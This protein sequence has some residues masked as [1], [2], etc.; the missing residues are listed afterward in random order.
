ME[1]EKPVQLL[2]HIPSSL[3]IRVATF[4]IKILLLRYIGRETCPT[5]RAYSL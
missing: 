4:I 3:V 2:E 1:E 5:P